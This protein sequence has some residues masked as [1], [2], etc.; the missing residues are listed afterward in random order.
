MF[1]VSPHAR[2]KQLQSISTEWDDVHCEWV[3]FLPVPRRIPDMNAPWMG[4]EQH[5]LQCENVW[6][7]VCVMKSWWLQWFSRQLSAIDLIEITM[8]HSNTWNELS[9]S[10]ETRLKQRCFIRRENDELNC[11]MRWCNYINNYRR[12]Y[13]DNDARS[14][15]ICLLLRLHDMSVCHFIRLVIAN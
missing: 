1:S 4:V 11:A 2:S 12:W 3:F 15:S 6:E 13:G 5:E 7:W 10:V 9:R 8:M 14:I